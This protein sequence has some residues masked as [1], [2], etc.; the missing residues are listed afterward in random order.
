[1]KKVKKIAHQMNNLIKNNNE[2]GE[3][4][5]SSNEQPNQEQQCEIKSTTTNLVHIHTL[6]HHRTIVILNIKLEIEQ[7]SYIDMFTNLTMVEKRL[8]EIN[9]INLDDPT[10]FDQV[11]RIASLFKFN[12]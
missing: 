5:C 7:H 8:H 3:E 10:N 1:M 12:I 2:K 6:I 9:V 4:D 11:Q